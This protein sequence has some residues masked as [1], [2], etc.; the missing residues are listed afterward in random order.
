MQR[1]QALIFPFCCFKLNPGLPQLVIL[2][3]YKRIAYSNAVSFLYKDALNT[4]GC[5]GT[6]ICLPKGFECTTKRDRHG[7]FA[8]R[9]F[10]HFYNRY[11]TRSEEHTSELQSR[12]HLVCRLLLEKK[13]H[14]PVSPTH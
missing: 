6:D 4:A 3:L 1:N 9:C 11:L 12:G 7:T 13:K 8:Y 10:H 2:H 5:I 14:E